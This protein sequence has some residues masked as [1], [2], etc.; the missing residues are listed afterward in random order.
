MTVQVDVNFEVAVV[1][2]LHDSLFGLIHSGLLLGAWVKVESIEVV[3]MR[4][5]T[6]VA[7]RH[8]VGV[9]QRYYLK[10][11]FFQQNSCL[12]GL[13]HNKVNYPIENVGAL[14][15]SRMHSRRKKNAGLVKFEAPLRAEQFRLF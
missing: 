4:V 3:I 5:K 13:R 12:I 15:F 8:T 9:H 1:V 6:V 11:I 7:S 2:L 10:L 14:Y